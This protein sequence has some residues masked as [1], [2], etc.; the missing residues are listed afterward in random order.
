MGQAHQAK[1]YQAATAGV[2]YNPANPNEV[3]FDAVNKWR[4][5]T[6]NPVKTKIIVTGEGTATVQLGS[7][8]FPKTATISGL[9]VADYTAGTRFQVWLNPDN[10]AEFSFQPRTTESGRKY[11]MVTLA[12]LMAFGGI[13]ALVVGKQWADPSKPPP[14]KMTFADM[15][16]GRSVA[17]ST[18]SIASLLRAIDWFQ[19]EAVAARILESEGW[20]V[21]KFGGANPDGGA[22]LLAI[23]NGRRSVVQCKHWRRIEVQPKIIRELLGTK[24]S[25][26]FRADGAVLF[27]LS[28]CTA[29]A[30]ACAKEND[31]TIY[32]SVAI[33]AAIQRLGVERF[34]ELV[35]PDSK[36]C[37]KC[38]AAMILRDKVET[39][40]WGCSTYPRCRGTIE[41]S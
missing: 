4:H 11:W 38:G 18:T 40:F 10:P 15:G 22:D 6:A 13:G 24:T 39:P 27:T 23:K 17:P 26:Q 20:V 31:V 3:R 28:N 1:N 21:Q 34:S 8:F 7:P 41:R 9:Q 19:F 36:H 2:Y 32:N 5:T 35:R 12:G 30:L 25:A 16:F 33:E 14:P 29:A 37:P